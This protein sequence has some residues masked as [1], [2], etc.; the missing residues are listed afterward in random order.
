MNLVENLWNIWEHV[1]NTRIKKFHPHF[2][3]PPPKAKNQVCFAAFFESF[4]ANQIY[5]ALILSWNFEKSTIA[6][7]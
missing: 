2:T 6:K 3:P 1:G 5:R 4:L 7:I